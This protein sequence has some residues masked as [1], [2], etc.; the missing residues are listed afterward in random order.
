[1]AALAA[2]QLTDLPPAAPTVIAIADDWTLGRVTCALPPCSP[3]VA[4][5]RPDTPGHSRTTPQDLARTTSHIQADEYQQ[6]RQHR[7]AHTRI[8]T[9]LAES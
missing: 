8:K 4:E 3:A 6:P 9:L 1:M 5:S 7:V 2:H